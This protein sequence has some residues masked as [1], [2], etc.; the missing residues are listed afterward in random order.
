MNFLLFHRYYLCI[1][2]RNVSL[3][4]F[5]WVN[6]YFVVV[7]LTNDSSEVIPNRGPVKAYNHAFTLGLSNINNPP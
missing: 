3:D 6:Y 7:I 4:N 2:P 5:A 1:Y